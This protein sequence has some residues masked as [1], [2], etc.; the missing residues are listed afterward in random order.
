M[1]AGRRPLARRG[2][3]FAFASDF[4]W[5]FRRLDEGRPYTRFDREK[6]EAIRRAFEKRLARG[7][8]LRI[9]DNQRDA[10]HRFVDQEILLGRLDPARRR[11]REQELLDSHQLVNRFWF[12]HVKSEETRTIERDPAK[13]EV[14]DALLQ[15]ETPE[16]VREICTDAYLIEIGEV[17]PGV[18]G[19]VQIPNWPIAH[20]SML[21][22]YLSHYATEIIAAKRERR[23]PKSARPSSRR[24]QMWFLSCALAGALYGVAPRTAINLIGSARPKEPSENSH[25]IKTSRTTRK[26][27][28]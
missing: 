21:P 14:V 11:E 10:V 12:L 6:F 24:R 25:A 3:Q 1:P 13:P 19:E 22:T 2:T 16:C 9:F 18:R 5:D 26:R 20:G 7:R 17:K 27:G 8:R 23:F 4:Y 15:A 28:M